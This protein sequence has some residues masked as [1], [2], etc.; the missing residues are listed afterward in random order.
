[1]KEQNILKGSK[2]AQDMQRQDP[3]EHI[4]K[5]VHKE[6]IHNC[7]D[8]IKTRSQATYTQITHTQWSRLGTKC[9]KTGSQRQDITKSSSHC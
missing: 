7:K 1:L 9:A 8:T 5:D 4:N 6:H 2:L 3:K